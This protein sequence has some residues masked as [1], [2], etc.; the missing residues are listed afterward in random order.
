MK[1]C[2]LSYLFIHY[3]KRM[4]AA[5]KEYFIGMDTDIACAADP[6]LSV[7]KNIND[8][9]DQTV[10]C[11]IAHAADLLRSDAKDISDEND[12]SFVEACNPIELKSDGGGEG[13]V[14]VGNS[15]ETHSSTTLSETSN[16]V[17]SLSD[18]LK[19][20]TSKFTVRDGNQLIDVPYAF[21]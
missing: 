11:A 13:L 16:N 14:M 19:F 4:S 6:T 1:I 18:Q 2:K 15:K 9:D 5:G 7:F 21:S 20:W 3:K 12:D 10:G 8:K 17:L